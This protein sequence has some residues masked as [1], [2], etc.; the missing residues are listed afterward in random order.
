M[1]KCSSYRPKINER[2]LKCADRVHK[3]PETLA[4]GPEVD[5]QIS[6]EEKVS[7]ELPIVT[8]CSFLYY[9]KYT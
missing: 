9:S 8:F 1:T 7:S 3:T 6:L 2:S 4:Q 5:S